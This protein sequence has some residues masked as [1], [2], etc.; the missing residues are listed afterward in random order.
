MTVLDWSVPV[1]T[2]GDPVEAIGMRAGLGAE[3]NSMLSMAMLSGPVVAYAG[4]PERWI[5]LTGP[6]TSTSNSVLADL[7]R[8]GV[9]LFPMGS[10]IALPCAENAGTARWIDRPVPNKP[11]P[12]WQAVVA[13]VR[14]TSSVSSGWQ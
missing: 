8:L 2:V 9:G 13:A 14:R 5:F 12:P 1:L 6:A 4:T 10:L 11:L 3:V 7:V